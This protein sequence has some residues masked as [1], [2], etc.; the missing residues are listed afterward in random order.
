MFMLCTNVAEVIAVAVAAAAGGIL[1]LPIPLRPLQILYLN[2]VTDVFPALALGM[3]K[4]DPD[5]MKADPRPRNESV[6]TRGHW[7]AIVGWAMFLAACVLTGLSVAFYG[8]NFDQ[9]QAVT[10]SF[11]TLAF[12]KLWF[13]YNLRH[14]GSRLFNNEIVRNPYVGIAIVLC[15]LLLLATVYWPGLSHLLKTQNPTRQGWMIVFVMSLVP[16]VFGQL[17]R[18]IQ[19]AYPK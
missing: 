5:V 1:N 7:A 13:V 18:I 9:R 10:V 12:G 11:L 19:K 16:F 17:L 3:G 14:A 2:M 15:A 6:V 8:L 4:G